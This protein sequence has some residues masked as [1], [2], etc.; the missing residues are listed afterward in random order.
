M[1]FLRAGIVFFRD[2][3]MDANHAERMHQ[4]Q[5][6]RNWTMDRVIGLEKAFRIDLDEVFVRADVI[7]QTMN[8]T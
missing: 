2:G 5:T 1:P 8:S 6:K 4:K 3:K 7:Y